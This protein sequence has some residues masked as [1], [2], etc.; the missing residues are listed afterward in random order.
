MHGDYLDVKDG[1]GKVTG[2]AVNAR[3]VPIITDGSVVGR[4]NKGQILQVLNQRDKWYRVTSPKNFKAWVKAEGFAESA[5]EPATHNASD[6]PAVKRP[7]LK[8]PKDDNRWLFEQASNNFTLQLASF[9]DAAK[10]EQFVSQNKFIN[11]PEL[12]SFTS[13]AKDIV[14]TYFLYGSYT[15]LDQAKQAKQE[16]GQKTARIRTFKKIQ[17]NRCI[18]WKTKFPSPKELNTFCG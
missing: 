1:I 14:W 3:A 2:S 11:N 8:R 5:S 4:F 13:S 7:T 9:D 18:A 6:T 12:H 17:Q 16:I 15:T 10:I